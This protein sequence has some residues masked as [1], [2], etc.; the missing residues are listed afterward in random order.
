MKRLLSV[1][2]A[3]TM[4]MPAFAITATNQSRRSVSAKMVA[5]APRQTASKNQLNPLQKSSVRV[6]PDDFDA[7][8]AA[9]DAKRDQE[10][11]ACEA[12]NI[13]I[14]NTFVW[15]SRNSNTSNY[16]TM[17][18]DTQNPDNNTCFALVS[19]TSNDSKIDL[20]GVVTPKYFEMGRSIVCGDWVDGDE[21]EKRI[22]KA[23]KTTRA[24]ATTGAVVGGVGLGVGAMELFG[25]KL[26]G[27]KVEG[28]ANKN[29]SD[30]EVL[31]SQLL[32]MQEKGQ[33]DDY[34]NITRQLKI[35]E[36]EC[37]NPIWNTN[38]KPQEIEEICSSF[39]FTVINRPVEKKSKKN[40]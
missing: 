2:I 13:G 35:I 15:A 9:A 20:N 25:N 22:L 36:E 19:I 3:M 5:P 28:Q 29:L 31:R 1:F 23:K 26:I 10:R 18:E 37:A 38:Q 33:M 11:K 6:Y 12:N 24:L 17:V 16:A 30:S 21:M 32:T 14:G 39:D 27:G 4:C 34:N 40:K 8:Q 7:D